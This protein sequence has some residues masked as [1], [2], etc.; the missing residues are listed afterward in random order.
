M[1]TEYLAELRRRTSRKPPVSAAS[2]CSARSACASCSPARD[3]TSPMV[4]RPPKWS[5]ASMARSR[6]P[7][8]AVGLHGAA[9]RASPGAWMVPRG[10][11]RRGATAATAGA[12]AG[13]GGGGRRG[14]GGGGGGGRERGG[15]GRGAAACRGG[16]AAGAGRGGGGGR[17]RRRAPW[18]G[19]GG[20]GGLGRGGHS[21]VRGVAVEGG[22]ERGERGGGVCWP[23]PRDR[24][25]SL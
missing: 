6:T 2:A 18:V 13:R 1:T 11:S 3:A 5:T 25:W 12:G 10:P 19:G 21:P 24:I 7:E 14:G 4:T 8:E 16:E 20:G 23:W 15:K 9:G 22:R 17:G